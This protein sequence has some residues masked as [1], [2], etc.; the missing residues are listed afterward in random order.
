MYVESYISASLS[1]SVIDI[2]VFLYIFLSFIKS[3]HEAVF[4]KNVLH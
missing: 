4:L 3:T 2:S 1:N